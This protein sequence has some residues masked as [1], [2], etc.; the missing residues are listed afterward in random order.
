MTASA[1]LIRRTIRSAG[2]LNEPLSAPLSH[3]TTTGRRVNTA[4]ANKVSKGLYPHSLP[5]GFNR[6]YDTVNGKLTKRIE[7]D[8]V[9]GPMI[10]Q[11][12]RLFATGTY[13]GKQI[14][15]KMR[16]L[17]L[18]S[19][20][21]NVVSRTQIETYLKDVKYTG[22]Q[23]RWKGEAPQDWHDNCPPLISTALFNEVQAVFEAKSRPE[24]RGGQGYPLKGLMVCGLC[25]KPYIEEDHERHYFRCTLQVQACSKMGSP[26]FKGH[27]LDLLL[28]TAIGLLDFEPSVYEWMSEQVEETFRLTRETEAVERVRLEKDKERAKEERANTLRAFT[29]GIGSEDDCKEETRKLTEEIE[30]IDRRLKEL[31][32]GEEMIIRNSLD[33]LGI[34]KDFKNQYL[35]A[36][37]EKRRRMHI[38]LFQE[39]LCPP[40]EVLEKRTTGRSQASV[41]S[42]QYPLEIEWD[43]LFAWLFEGRLTGELGGWPMSWSGNDADGSR[44]PYFWTKTK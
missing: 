15:A 44:N 4:Y 1:P 25:G 2:S 32:T 40:A 41:A 11:M 16:D 27:E 22:Q 30:R 7:I 5:L 26:R 20:K 29:K 17:G 35:S 10:Q 18:R 33:T 12:F 42:E 14:A 31:D 39:D 8:P 9:R 43:E 19:R 13:N 24:S 37:P 23:F 38:L 6:V 36:E 21:G 3:P 28:E 34:L